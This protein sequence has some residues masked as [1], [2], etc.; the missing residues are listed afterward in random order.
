MI[1]STRLPL[2]L[3]AVATVVAGCSTSPT[4]TIPNPLAPINAG[5]ASISNAVR[6]PAAPAY[7]SAVPSFDTTAPQPASVAVPAYTG[8]GYENVGISYG[9]PTLSAPSYS[10]PQIAAPSYSVPLYSAPTLGSFNGGSNIQSANIPTL[11]SYTVNAPSTSIPTL[12]VPAEYGVAAPSFSA[13]GINVPSF[14][15]PSVNAPS[16]SAPSVAAPSFGTSGL[17]TTPVTYSAGSATFGGNT[18]Y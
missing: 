17:T 18:Y 7:T 14:S 10:A 1:R 11:G 2:G 5:L 6:V 3:F 15:A 8:A 16:F 4:I 12:G 9:T 13:P